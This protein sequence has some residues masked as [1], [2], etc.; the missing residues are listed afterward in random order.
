MPH[1][2]HKAVCYV[3]HN[4]HILVF[5]HLDVPLTVTGVQIP[6][7]SIKDCESADQ[8]AVR[9]LFEETGRRGHVVRKVG[10]QHYDLRPMR[11]EVA[12]RH[13]FQMTL[14]HADVTERWAAGEPDPATGGSAV[15]WDCWWLPIE[16]AHVLVAG[17]GGLLGAMLEKI[18]LSE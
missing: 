14:P 18:P 4:G 3:V 9:E 10:V 8:A 13:Y 6:A 11:D 1:E 12:V 2:V 7:G 16:Q 15:A 17:F 5:T